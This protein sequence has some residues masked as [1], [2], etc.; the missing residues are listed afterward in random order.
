MTK[1]DRFGKIREKF[2]CNLIFTFNSAKNTKKN[3]IFIINVQYSKKCLFL[4][5]FS[6]QIQ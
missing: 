1:S 2:A 4:S 6:N 3:K 5:K